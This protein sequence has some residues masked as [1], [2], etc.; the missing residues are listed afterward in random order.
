MLICLK[1]QSLIFN[2]VLIF[3]YLV[4][5]L[6]AACFCRISSSV[7]YPHTVGWCLFL[8][9]R[10]LLLAARIFLSSAES[11]ATLSLSYSFTVSH[12]P[13]DLSAILISL[14]RLFICAMQSSS[15]FEG[16]C[17]AP[18]LS[19]FCTSSSVPCSCSLNEYCSSF[20]LY[21]KS[22]SLFLFDE[23]FLLL[24]NFISNPD[25][26]LSRYLLISF[27]ESLSDMFKKL[28]CLVQ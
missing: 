26:R 22:F 24:R 17:F 10:T 5:W 25:R 9:E 2:K 6:N 4:W 19:K 12:P 18:F 15:F 7:L 1:A 27:T 14:F 11:L 20:D 23:L 16:L 28:I 21:L 3:S 8:F 13:E